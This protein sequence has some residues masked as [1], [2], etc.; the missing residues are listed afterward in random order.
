MADALDLVVDLDTLKVRE[1]EELED[2]TGLS[3]D[4]VFAAG[5]PRGKALRA[6]AFIV[7]KRDKP[8]F[9]WEEAGELTVTLRAADPTSAAG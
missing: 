9:T 3:I 7:T 4:A 6:I 2:L 8:E 5:A 1:I